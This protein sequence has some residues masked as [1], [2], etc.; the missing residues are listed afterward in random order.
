MGVSGVI[1]HEL[2]ISRPPPL[3]LTRCPRPSVLWLLPCQAATS[4]DWPGCGCSQSSQSHGILAIN[5]Q[6][7][8][9]HSFLLPVL[10]SLGGLSWH[11][12][13]D[14]EVLQSLVSSFGFYS[15]SLYPRA[16][17]LPSQCSWAEM[18]LSNSNL[19]IG[20]SACPSFSAP[21][22]KS[23]SLC[24][25]CSL[26]DYFPGAI[27]SVQKHIFHWVLHPFNRNPKRDVAGVPYTEDF[28][29]VQIN[30]CNWL[31]SREW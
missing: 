26:M 6:S 15:Q 20:Y 5:P 30:L 31:L 24:L 29:P 2:W 25:I 10:C 16:T 18:D 23:D 14:P 8:K 13:L 27:Q 28:V 21:L 1:L 22:A 7:Q 9:G 19:V 4:A 12:Y 3:Q 11:G 17:H